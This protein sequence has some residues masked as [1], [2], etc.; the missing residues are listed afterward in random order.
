MEEEQLLF[1]TIFK[2]KFKGNNLTNG[3]LGASRTLKNLL[4]IK[5]LSLSRGNDC[6]LVVC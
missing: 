5:K 1:C 2:K 4:D 3:P 6:K